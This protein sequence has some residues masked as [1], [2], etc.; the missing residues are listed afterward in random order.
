MK[1]YG[2]VGRGLRTNCLDYGADP[3]TPTPILLQL[4]TPK[5]E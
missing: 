3:M 2:E 1:F 5:M 4:F